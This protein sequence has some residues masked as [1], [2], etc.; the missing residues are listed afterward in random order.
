MIRQQNA[1]SDVPV[2]S[3]RSSDNEC[4]QF[5]VKLDTWRTL[6][7]LYRS[8]AIAESLSG[9]VGPS[10]NC[11]LAFS[12]AFDELGNLLMISPTTF[13]GL[14][15]FSR[16]LCHEAC[17]DDIDLLSLGVKTMSAAAL[18]LIPDQLPPL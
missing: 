17:D 3:C 11:D 4:D 13:K 15:E 9:I 1:A 7:S 12:V 14:R 6:D 2:E 10:E 18:A 8:I 5:L 16:L